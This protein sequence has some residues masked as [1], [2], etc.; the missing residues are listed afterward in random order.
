[1]I[2]EILQWLFILQLQ[3][4]IM[5][6]VIFVLRMVLKKAPRI[7]SYLLWLFLFVR[8]LCPITLESP[9][10]MIPAGEQL[11]EAGAETLQNFPLPVGGEAENA[12]IFA[13][14]NKP[15]NPDLGEKQP[16]GA[17]YQI[18]SEH[19]APKPEQNAKTKRNIGTIL[20]MAAVIIWVGGAAALMLY[21]LITL[22]RLKRSLASA[23]KQE[24]GYFTS[25]AIETPFVLGIFSPKIYLPEG[26][27]GNELSYILAHE[28]THL[29]RKDYLIKPICLFL[30]CLYWFNPFVWAAFFL[31]GKD[32]E[33]SCDEHVLN[34]LGEDIKADYSE[35]LLQFASG[36]KYIA[37]PLAFGEN[38]VK[39]RVRNVLRFKKAKLW[40]S[41]A[42]I[43]LCIAAGVLLLTT[44][45]GREP[46]LRVSG[47][48]D[49]NKP[50]GA[51][52]PAGAGELDETEKEPASFLPEEMIEAPVPTAKVEGDLYTA[53]SRWASEYADGEADIPYAPDVF[54]LAKPSEQVLIYYEKWSNAPEITILI[55]VLSYT[56]TEDGYQLKR[57][58]FQLC[59]SI[60]SK[61]AFEKVYCPL[62]EQNPYLFTGTFVEIIVERMALH[63]G[64]VS[65]FQLPLTAAAR[66]LHLGEGQGEI[67]FVN[68]EE[69]I[70][71]CRYT[72]HEDGSVVEIP[73]HM[74][75]FSYP[76]WTVGDVGNSEDFARQ[77][78]IAS[79]EYGGE[80]Y[81]FYPTG[82]YKVL[83]DGS[84]K[85][86][87]A[88]Y[89]SISAY[90]TAV[91]SNGSAYFKIDLLHTP[92][93][94][95]YMENAVIEVNLATE[96][97]RLVYAD[98]DCLEEVVHLRE[99]GMDSV[100]LQAAE[101]YV[102]TLAVQKAQEEK[103]ESVSLR[104][105]ITGILYDIPLSEQDDY[106]CKASFDLNLDGNMDEIKLA[107]I[108]SG[109]GQYLLMI[110]DSAVQFYADNLFYDRLQVI[111]FDGK[112]QLLLLYDD[113]PS[114]DP[115]TT[116]YRYRG[117]LI[118][119]MGSIPCEMGS[120]TISEEGEITG[121]YRFDV[122]QSEWAAVTWVYTE[123][124]FVIKEQPY[125]DYFYDTDL[126]LL[127]N[128][129]VHSEMSLESEKT[130]LTP[131]KVKLLYTDM[132]HWFYVEGENKEGG[133]FY[134]EERFGMVP[135]AE[136]NVSAVFEGLSYAG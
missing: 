45:Q 76:V 59:D 5:A 1:M 11:M 39:E 28:K 135:E 109:E 78:R 85:C 112:E 81:C 100:Q 80:S 32:M 62:G 128:L 50:D 111:S 61:E 12:Q 92:Y 40:I 90:E 79:V 9:V 89:V 29:L 19:I 110:N 74:G 16:A 102:R 43:L 69:T 38:G 41:A 47:Q 63:D 116:A 7:Y 130:V 96:E 71:V 26:I 94:L 119:E 17:D 70:A 107:A 3:V 36:R 101:E 98:E 60:A 22:K 104:Q 136:V 66:A 64:S 35:S 2:K 42:A 106:G 118:R 53:V 6:A 21:N 87:Y 46:D 127:V 117:G 82:F 55:E 75:E 13:N 25:A 18:L 72:F 133:W 23:K 126:T 57:D 95:D 73:L 125:Y 124:G 44:R 58:G 123:E 8:L 33:M 56:E 113:G 52:T 134:V 65:D 122:I 10:S 99:N 77:E 108:N 114:G 31:M 131:Q 129:P 121:S 97:W 103:G 24:G 51:N 105:P 88:G 14:G 4:S 86:L 54:Y 120:C 132:E 91:V 49:T 83:P 37:V 30:T 84:L 27:C 115:K 15:Q 20:P 68:E 48:E 67:S 34:R 93:S